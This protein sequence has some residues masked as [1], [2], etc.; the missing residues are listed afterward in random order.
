MERA[1]LVKCFNDLSLKQA[2]SRNAL[3]QL[4][5]KE[6]APNSAVSWILKHPILLKAVYLGWLFHSTLVGQDRLHLLG[7][8]W[9]AEAD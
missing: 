1:T 7:I 8:T 9:R 4:Q 5:P 3:F 6:R 2:F